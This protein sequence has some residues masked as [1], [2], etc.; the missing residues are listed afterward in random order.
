MGT[1]GSTTSED[2]P[3]D[4]KNMYRLRSKRLQAD[5]FYKEVV[6]P[7]ER[8]IRAQRA[9]RREETTFS[10]ST[11][12]QEW[13]SAQE[14]GYAYYQDY[15]Q[16]WY[17]FPEDDP[18]EEIGTEWQCICPEG[19]AGNG[20]Y[21][22]SGSWTVRMVLTFEDYEQGCED[23]WWDEPDT[24]DSIGN[25]GNSKLVGKAWLDPGK[26]NRCQ[27][28]HSDENHCDF[29]CPSVAWEDM[30]EGAECTKECFGNCDC[31]CLHWGMGDGTCACTNP[32]DDM[33]VC[34]DPN[35]NGD[36]VCFC[37]CDQVTRGN[38]GTYSNSLQ[39]PGGARRAFEEQV[40][41]PVEK[42]QRAKA[43]GGR[44]VSRKLLSEHEERKA[45]R[46]PSPPRVKAAEASVVKEARPQRRTV[47]EELAGGV[48]YQVYGEGVTFGYGQGYPYYVHTDCPCGL[49]PLPKPTEYWSRYW[50]EVKQ[51]Y[52]NFLTSNENTMTYESLVRPPACA[53]AL[54]GRGR[55][56]GRG[57]A[58]GWGR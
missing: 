7:V 10:G 52:A 13:W 47:E 27:G 17:Q 32:G 11:Q 3:L 18:T 20:T 19:V 40:V 43:L 9:A 6:E 57:G 35:D 25:C 24:D 28:S 53:R 5:G 31:D 37:T 51:V 12:W 16:S 1:D 44:R 4:P 56:R 36:I 30:V 2:D 58:W 29:L 38:S 49:P 39:G 48:G 50:K 26:G 22:E 41:A 46:G 23:D 34:Q 54:W 45:K 42:E 21:C 14:G 33:C 55:G 8:K 15:W